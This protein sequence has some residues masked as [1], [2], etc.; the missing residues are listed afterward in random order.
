MA[1]PTSLGGGRPA[2]PARVQTARRRRAQP[3]RRRSTSS[4]CSWRARSSSST[5]IR[6]PARS[7]RRP[8]DAC[9]RALVALDGREQLV[10]RVMPREVIVDEVGVGSGTIVEQELARRLHAASIAQVTIERSASGRELGAVLLRSH[11]VR[12]PAR[13]APQPHRSPRRARRQ[14]HRPARR[15]PAAGRSRS[16]R[17]RRR[18]RASSSSSARAATSSSPPAARS[19]ISILPT[20]A[21]SASI[22]RRASSRSRSSTWRSSRRI[23]RRSPACSCG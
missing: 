10:F 21:G 6:R 15:V 20:R 12:H 19:I 23:P 3:T 7:A 2:A 18:S 4:C 9:Q 16:A 22:R 1:G 14:P 17:R 11:P 8:I 5:P 13:A